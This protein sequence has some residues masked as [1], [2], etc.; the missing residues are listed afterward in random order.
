MGGE[1][2]GQNRRGG[3]KEPVD[4]WDVFRVG[5][6]EALMGMLHRTGRRGGEEQT[7][8]EKGERLSTHHQS[9][10]GPNQGELLNGL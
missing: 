9:D 10:I 1:K 2:T 3:I 5:G 6:L 4:A 7:W 8:P